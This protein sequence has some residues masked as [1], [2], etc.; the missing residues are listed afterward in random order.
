[1]EDSALHARHEFDD[2]GFAD[3]LNEA[4]DDGVAELAVGHLAAAEAKAGLD[5]VAIVE[6][7]D[8]LIFLGLVVVVVDGDGELDFLDGD[9]LL[10][11][12]GGAVALFLLV[13]VAAVI[14]DAAD[15]RDRGGRNLN[16]IEP[17][18]TSDFQGLKGRQDAE[19]FAVFVDDADFAC[20]NAVVD[21]DKG[22][23]RTFV[24]CDGAPPLGSAPRFRGFPESKRARER[25][26]SIPLAQLWR[27]PVAAEFRRRRE[28]RYGR[29]RERRRTWFR[30][31]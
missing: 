24:E 21:A 25:T 31:P 3:V 17:A 19:L 1:M 8:G 30:L 11:F 10:L 9:D 7:A 15:G 12:A 16:Q 27:L 26:L 28:A 6:E 14:L 2:A 5:L 22:L 13:E 20:A 4:V 23:C 18:F 29:R